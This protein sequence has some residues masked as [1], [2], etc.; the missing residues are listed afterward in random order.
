MRTSPDLAGVTQSGQLPYPARVNRRAFLRLGIAAAAFNVVPRKVLG[1]TGS[2][3][4][5]GKTTLAAIGLGGQGMQ[6]L[7]TFLAFPEIQ[8]V[9]V[10]DVDRERSGYVSWNGSEGKDTRVCGREP[11]RRL[12]A[13]EGRSTASGWCPTPWRSNMAGHRKPSQD[14]PDTI[15][16]G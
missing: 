11:G 10:C 13:D 16:N 2:P 6:N 7:A 4:P 12:V 3:S 9:A 8:V 5:N 1:A 14:R 15:T